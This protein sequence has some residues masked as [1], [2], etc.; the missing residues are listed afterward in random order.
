MLSLIILKMDWHSHA[1]L[2]MIGGVDTGPCSED[3]IAAPSV[4]TPSDEMRKCIR[5]Y[6]P[7]NTTTD[8]KKAPNQHQ[9]THW[10]I[11]ASQT[12]RP[13][14]NCHRQSHLRHWEFNAQPL[15]CLLRHILD[16]Q[17]WNVT[18]K[19]FHLWTSCPHSIFIDLLEIH[20][21]TRDTS[22]P[23]D[24][25]KKSNPPAYIESYMYMYIC[26]V[27]QKS[28]IPPKADDRKRNNKCKGTLM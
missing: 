9:Q 10:H 15:P 8:I 1:T 11:S 2:V 21:D 22:G 27:C 7:N 4:E 5:M 20:Q 28:T 16:L 26:L 6:D 12:K 17:R 14:S 24:I 13:K 25:T 23:G 18:T 3:I 19:L